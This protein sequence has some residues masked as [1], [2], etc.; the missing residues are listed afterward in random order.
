M[1]PGDADNRS[2]GNNPTA[3]NSK[4]P[5]ASQK[6]DWIKLIRNTTIAI[7]VAIAF[8]EAIVNLVTAIPRNLQL[9]KDLDAT[10][11]RTHDLLQETDKHTR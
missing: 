1:I 2:Q 10:Y 4:T 11:K 3:T 5:I 7:G 6:R 9:Q 8:F